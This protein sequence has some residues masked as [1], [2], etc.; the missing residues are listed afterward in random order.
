MKTNWN[1]VTMESLALFWQNFLLF[2]PSLLLGLLLL[3]FGWFV[4]VG[5]GKLTT[6][7]LK[8][9][10]FDVFFEKDGW[11][12]AMAKAKIN[13]K[14]SGFIGSIVKWMIYVLFLWAAVG[15]FGLVYFTRF[16][17]DI[18]AYI[19]SVIVASL[20][21][22][23][24]AVLADF[25]SKIIVTL[26]E[27]VKFKHTYFVGEIARWAIW[28]FAGFAILIELGIAT[29]LLSILFTGIVGI[30]V[31]AGGIAFG[32]GGKDIAGEIIREFKDKLKE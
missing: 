2:L 9:L 6:E 4:S 24:A 10:K 13:I 7:I 14:A 11:K 12:E 20:I 30:M 18:V 28:I 22:V 21:F 8:K 19:P 25:V 31:I 3:V 17:G 15:T 32:L 29:E 5:L 26:T 27:K 16:M 23:V 1:I